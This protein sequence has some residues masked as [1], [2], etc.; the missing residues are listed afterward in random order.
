MINKNFE[1][2]RLRAT[3]RSRGLDENTVTTLV[4]KAD[5]EIESAMAERMQIAMNEAIAAGVEKKS[6]D[7]I[8]DL[9]PAPGAFQ[10]DTYSGN[11][12]FTEPPYPM[13]SHLLQGAKPMK[14]GSGVYKVIPVGEPSK[15]PK[16]MGNIFDTQKAIEVERLEAAKAQYNKVAPAGSKAK[17]RTATSKQSQLTNWVLPTK[18]ADFTSTVKEINNDLD[19]ALESIIVDVIRDYEENF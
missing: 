4:N 6:A 3:L 13:L 12:D 1:L 19:S 8:N 17:F 11:L 16:V 2:E 5:D 15:K 9:R 14:D 18:E 10:L 7:F